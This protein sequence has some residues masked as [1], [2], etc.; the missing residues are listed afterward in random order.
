MNEQ[1]NAAEPT[2]E[3]VLRAASIERE[4]VCV[5]EGDNR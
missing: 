2:I 5:R 3:A 4:F 1:A